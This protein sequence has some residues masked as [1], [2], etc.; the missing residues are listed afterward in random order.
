MQ[1][2]NKTHKRW[3]EFWKPDIRIELWGMEIPD[4]ELARHLQRWTESYKESKKSL[5]I[6]FI[7][8]KNA[9]IILGNISWD[10]LNT[11]FPKGFVKI[12]NYEI[13]EDY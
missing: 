8:K 9:N 13:Q 4:D 6:I 7:L 12:V 11:R 5:S 10:F 2:I 1:F 3:Y